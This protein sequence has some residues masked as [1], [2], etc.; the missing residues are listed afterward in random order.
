MAALA[1]TNSATPSLSATLMRSRLEAAKR[2]ASQAQAEVDQL[3]NQVTQAETVS[4]QRQETVRR[5]SDQAQSADPTY[6]AQV[7]TARRPPAE[8]MPLVQMTSGA[9]TRRPLRS[10]S[11]NAIP[12]TML[13]SSP[14]EQ[15]SGRIV[16]LSA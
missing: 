7:K 3:R 10:L 12:L 6:D 5:L 11:P 13:V 4:A 2:E 1:A 14:R 16:N 8:L 9:S 15:V